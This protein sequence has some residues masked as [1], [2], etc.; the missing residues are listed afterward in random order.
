MRYAKY[1]IVSVQFD[2]R[3]VKVMAE[4]ATLAT[5]NVTAKPPDDTFK[6]PLNAAFHYKTERRR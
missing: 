3:E 1:R 5:P 4:H 2:L 6:P